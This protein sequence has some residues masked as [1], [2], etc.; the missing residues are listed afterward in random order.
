MNKIGEEV[1]PENAILKQTI[2]RMRADKD[3]TIEKLKDIAN[4][5]DKDVKEMVSGISKM[6]TFFRRLLN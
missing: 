2:E 1:T 6:L 4:Y 3:M 5:A